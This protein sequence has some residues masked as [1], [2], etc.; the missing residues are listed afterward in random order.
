M[1]QCYKGLVKGIAQVWPP[2][3]KH[4]QATFWPNWDGMANV[5]KGLQKEMYKF[6]C[7]AQ[8]MPKQD[9]D[10]MG[11]GWPMVNKPKS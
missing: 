9:F 4:A 3:P 5:I 10:Q 11:V 8:N 6:E 1:G 7:L 2:C